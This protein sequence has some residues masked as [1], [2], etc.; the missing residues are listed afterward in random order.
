MTVIVEVREVGLVRAS[1]P[2]NIEK[3]LQGFNESFPWLH[4]VLWDDK[5]LGID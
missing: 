1:Q 5:E 3:Q 2:V 4:S